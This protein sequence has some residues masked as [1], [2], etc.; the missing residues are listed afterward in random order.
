[1]S[2]SVIAYQWYYFYCNK[3]SFNHLVLATHLITQAKTDI[4]ALTLQRQLG[5]CYNT[6]WSVKHKLMQVMQERDDSK[7]LTGIIQLDDEYWGGEYHGGKR[8]CGS[9]NKTPL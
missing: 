5:V 9:P 1:L 8:G 2:S 4:A 7:L 6:A 3:T